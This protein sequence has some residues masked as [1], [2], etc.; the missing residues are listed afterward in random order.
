[1]VEGVLYIIGFVIGAGSLV[2][3]AMVWS[4]TGN[5]LAAIPTLSGLISGVL[6][7][8]FGYLI[9][10]VEEIRDQNASQQKRAQAATQES[11]AS[12]QTGS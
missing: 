7:G 2:Y 4:G 8:A 5:A 6:I 1:V 11:A 3:G 10:L 9:A 12:E